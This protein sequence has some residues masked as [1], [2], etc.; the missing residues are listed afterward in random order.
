MNPGPEVRRTK[1][2]P[3][4]ASAHARASASVRYEKSGGRL[5]DVVVI[6]CCLAAT[7]VNLKKIRK[8][9]I[10]VHGYERIST[11]IVTYVQKLRSSGI[12]RE[13]RV[14]VLVK[15]DS[16][17]DITLTVLKYFF[18]TLL[19]YHIKLDM[20]KESHKYSF[21]HSLLHILTWKT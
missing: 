1:V 15:Y 11:L 18:K 9:L 3:K 10:T 17:V 12:L 14:V 6:Y 16:G 4:M 8:G 20:F 19:L 13:S 2:R 7:G 5:S 21:E